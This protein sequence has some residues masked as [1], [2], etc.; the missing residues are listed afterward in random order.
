M[1]EGPYGHC[2]NN[3]GQSCDAADQRVRVLPGTG[4]L[5]AK[6]MEAEPQWQ[7]LYCGRGGAQAPCGAPTLLLVSASAVQ[8]N[9]LLKKLP[10]FRQVRSVHN[11][12]CVFSLCVASRLDLQPCVYLAMICIA[13]SPS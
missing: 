2:R 8:A 3:H 11:S 1:V 12:A 6:L 13:C 10:M 7:Q 4:T 9:A 5:E